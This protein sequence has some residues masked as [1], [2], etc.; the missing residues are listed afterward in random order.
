MAFGTMESRSARHSGF[1]AAGEGVVTR[2]VSLETRW[3]AMGE[4]V[5]A[6]TFC[7]TEHAWFPHAQ[8]RHGATSVTVWGDTAPTACI[9]RSRQPNTMFN[10]ARTITIYC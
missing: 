4:G 3:A 7:G 10:A 9:Q 5:G 2:S 1:A 6:G 8:Q